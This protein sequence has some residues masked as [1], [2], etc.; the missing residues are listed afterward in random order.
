MD[1]KKN[2]ALSKFMSY[3]L[4]HHPQD[5]KLD[6]D[7]EGWVDVSRL[8][9]NAKKYGDRDFTVEEV[10]H[11]VQTNAKKRFALSEDKTRIRANQGHSVEVHLDLPAVMP[12]EFLYHGTAERFLDAILKEGLKPMQRHDVHLSFD[13]KTALSVGQRHGTPAILRVKA[14]EMFE[15]GYVFKC[16]VNNVWLTQHVPVEFLERISLDLKPKM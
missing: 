5:I 4:R 12:P 9:E 3:I 1:Q 6:L 8:V 15:K 11:V 2:D 10:F 13:T 14:L 16:T 7:K